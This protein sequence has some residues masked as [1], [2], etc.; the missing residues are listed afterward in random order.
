MLDHLYAASPLV[1]A[2][3]GALRDAPENTLAAFRR[4]MALGA[5]GVELDVKLTRDG[6]PII[7]HDATADRTTDGTGRIADLT[8][9]ELK[10]LDAGSWFDVEFKGERVPR[11]DEAFEELGSRAIVNVELT[12]YATSQD[13]LEA[14]VVELIHRHN[15]SRRVILSS[16]NPMSIRRVKQLDPS[17]P[18]AILTMP[19]LAIWLRR[20]WLAPF[21]PHEAR[22]PERSEVSEAYMR[23]CRRRRLRV[24]AWSPAELD[25]KPDEVRRLVALGV[26]GIICNQPEVVN[27]VLG[28]AS[29]TNP[30]SK[31]TI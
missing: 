14:K 30:K 20:V 21:V 7:M 9:A 16:F 26:D 17:L 13:G 25:D 3:R 18:T 5:D 31:K 15:L 24:N 27:A 10:S 2:H 4:A 29:Q 1:L 12:N 8:L 19:G 11:L 23:G 28:R 22:H 6:V